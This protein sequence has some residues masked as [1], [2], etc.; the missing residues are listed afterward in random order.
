MC[1]ALSALPILDVLIIAV[2]FVI[3]A[4]AGGVAIDVAGH[5]WLV[6]CTLSLAL[7]LGFAKRE[8]ERVALGSGGGRDA[9]RRVGACTMRKRLPT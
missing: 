1:W 7:F 2:G 9:A 3:R 8:S 6:L 4:Y 5:P